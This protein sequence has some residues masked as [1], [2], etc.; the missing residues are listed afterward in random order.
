M[1]VL[2]GWDFVYG[3]DTKPVIYSADCTEGLLYKKSDASTSP[4][5]VIV[6]TAGALPFGA[7]PEDRDISEV[8]ARGTVVARGKV[9]LVAAAAITDTDVP[10]KAAASGQ[11]TPCTTDLDIIVGY[12]QHT[13][14][15]GS[16]VLVDL[17]QMGSQYG[18]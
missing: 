3:R 17:A 1:A 13:A 5:T 8:G 6:C 18:A 15:S 16:I 10:L 11:V 12:A 9:P 4:M 7:A 14:A 2:Q